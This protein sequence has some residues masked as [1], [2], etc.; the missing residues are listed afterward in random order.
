MVPLHPTEKLIQ[1]Q[2]VMTVGKCPVMRTLRRPP[3]NQL[4]ATTKLLKAAVKRHTV[5]LTTD[6]HGPRNILTHSAIITLC[7]NESQLIVQNCMSCAEECTHTLS[8]CLVYMWRL[9]PLNAADHG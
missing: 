6:S 5:G 2:R 7:Y 8:I 4:H 3:R 9:V 1:I